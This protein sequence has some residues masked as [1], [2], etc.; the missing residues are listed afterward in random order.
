MIQHAARCA[1]WLPLLFMIPAAGDGGSGG[2]GGGGG[3]ELGGPNASVYFKKMLE[4]LKC[5]IQLRCRQTAA[6]Q[7]DA[8]FSRAASDP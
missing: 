3:F 2:W 5:A 6:V 1:P 8:L 7:S 4:L